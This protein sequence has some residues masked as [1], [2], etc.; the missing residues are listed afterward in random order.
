MKQ[1]HVYDA[2]LLINY[3]GS[4]CNLLQSD[5]TFKSYSG[6]SAQSDPAIHSFFIYNPLG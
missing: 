3:T 2:E 5:G 6:Y 1:E 4:T